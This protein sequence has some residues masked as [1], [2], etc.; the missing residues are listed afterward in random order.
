MLQNYNQQYLLLRRYARPQTLGANLSN[1]MVDV[2]IEF[3]IAVFSI[4]CA[5]FEKIMYNQL[6]WYVIFQLTVTCV[7][8]IFPV[9]LINELICPTPKKEFSGKKYEDVNLEFLNVII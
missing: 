2:F 7:V 9:H 8:F 3:T 1:E 5:V 6:S 4:G